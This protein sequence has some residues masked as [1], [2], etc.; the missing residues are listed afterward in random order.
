VNRLGIYGG[1]FDPVHCGHLA[2]AET[3]RQAFALRRVL[4]VPANQS[5]LRA[6]PLASA[7]DRLAMVGRAIAGTPAFEAAALD[8]ERP[9][10]SFMID[11][12]QA[13]AVQHPRAEFFLILG[14]DALAELPAWRHADRILALAQII[15]VP[16]PGHS[17]EIPSEVLALNPNAHQRIHA[18]RMPP[19]D[20][21]ASR[22]RAH[23]ASGHS[24]D[25]WVPQAVADYIASRGLYADAEPEPPGA[26]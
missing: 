1:T 8:I 12:L 4:F 17:S 10:P 7:C 6:P 2:V 16:R 11:T 25:A 24:V 22:I 21:A 20:I 26:I 15:A 23:C 5:P 13:L 18:Q 3:V 9:G 19:V 14:A